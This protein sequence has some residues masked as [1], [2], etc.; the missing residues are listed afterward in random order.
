MKSKLN[1]IDNIFPKLL[2]DLTGK[3]NQYDTQEI[4]NRVFQHSLPLSISLSIHIGKENMNNSI[5]RVKTKSIIN[6]RS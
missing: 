2:F 5:K 3:H 4:L 1:G 6:I